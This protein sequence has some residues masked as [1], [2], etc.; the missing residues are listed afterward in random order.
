MENKHVDDLVDA[1][2]LGAL[3]PDEV[4][5]VERHLQ[6]CHACQALVAEARRASELLLYAA[7]Q[8]APPAA[9]RGR[10]LAR[11]AEEKAATA[12]DGTAE[13]AA[14]TVQ[15]EPQ[16]PVAADRGPFQRLLAA[17]RNEP[18]PAGEADALLRDLLAD[19][20]VV[21]WPTNG[22]EAEPGASGRLVVSPRRRDAVF[23][24]SGLRRPE[25]GKA[26][27]VW[28]LRGGQPLP[29]AL[30]AVNRAGVGAG[31][32][33]ANE[34][35]PAFDTVAVTPEPLGGSPAPTGPIVLAGALTQQAS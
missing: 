1:Y 5:V 14:A 12:R 20:Q 29:N 11:I 3:E 7:P 2:A 10:V 9:L 18:A 8:V 34:P 22:T 30:F 32:V 4:D 13:S 6:T 27:Q 21:I 23:V 33:H 15:P 19:P 24:A 26:Y 35:W 25:A 17:L 28:L 16:P 31:I